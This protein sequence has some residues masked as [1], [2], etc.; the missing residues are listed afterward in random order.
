[1]DIAW[2]DGAS[3]SGE[4]VWKRQGRSRLGVL[5]VFLTGL[6]GSGTYDRTK[7]IPICVRLS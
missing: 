6:R 2:P 7:F 4:R 3:Q 1:M 5:A